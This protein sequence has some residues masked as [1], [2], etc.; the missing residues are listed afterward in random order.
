MG[1]RF[2]SA[3]SPLTGRTNEPYRLR[4]M[5]LFMLIKIYTFFPKVYILTCQLSAAYGLRIFVYDK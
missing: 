5:A 1:K 2:Y 3:H 4:G